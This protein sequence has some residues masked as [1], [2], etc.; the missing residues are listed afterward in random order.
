[1]QGF[2]IY[3]L[4]RSRKAEQ[5]ETGN[6]TQKGQKPRSGRTKAQKQT[7]GGGEAR[8]RSHKKKRAE[9]LQDETG[10]AGKWRIRK[11]QQDQKDGQ[12]TQKSQTQKHK[13]PHKIALPF[14]QGVI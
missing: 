8:Q 3:R 12:K 11:A 13:L 9:A 5:E 6:A 2:I 10:R 4:E 1:M 14:M 7:I